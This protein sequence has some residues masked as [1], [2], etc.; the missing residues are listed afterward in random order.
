[1]GFE[2]VVSVLQGVRSNYDDGSLQA[3]HQRARQELLSTAGLDRD[4]LADLADPKRAVSYRVIA[5]H[6]DYFP[7]AHRADQS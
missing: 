2:R 5:D 3:D 1:M 7:M 6:G 4:V